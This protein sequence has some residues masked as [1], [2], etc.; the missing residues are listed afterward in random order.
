MEQQN[1]NESAEEK[2]LTAAFQFFEEHE[3]IASAV[4]VNR[5]V[6]GL[7]NASKQELDNI[8]QKDKERMAEGIKAV[9]AVSQ[10]IQKIGLE[11]FATMN[12]EKKE[13]ELSGVMSQVS[14]SRYANLQSSAGS[15]YAISGL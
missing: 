8:P 4:G 15:E 6:I 5:Q 9:Y 14:A 7:K 11:K 12:S 3:Y 2:A 1:I 10:E 13:K